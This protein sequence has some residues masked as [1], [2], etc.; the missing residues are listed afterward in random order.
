MNKR[1]YI[2]L[3]IFVICAKP[4]FAQEH[5]NSFIQEII[6]AISEETEDEVDFS[7]L[8]EELENLYDN[9]LDINNATAE[10]LEK[11]IMLN[12][13]QIQSLT[14]Y[15]HKHGKLL[16]KYELKNIDGFNMKTVN[17]VLPF[18]YI[19]STKEVRQWTIKNAFKY[20]R[21]DLFVRFTTLAQEPVGYKSV[22]DSVMNAE[23][24]KHYIGNRHRVYSRYKFN[25]KNKLQFGITAEKDP[26]EQFF[27][28]NQKYGFDYYSGHLMVKDVGIL[29]TAV[30]GDY[31]VLLGQGLTMWS[32]VSGGKSAYVMDIRR[33]GQGLKKYSSV[34]ENSFLRGV[35]ATVSFKN[36]SLTTFGSYKKVDANLSKPTDTLTLDENLFTSFDKMGIHA[37]PR[38]IDNKDAIAEMLAGAN[39]SW[40]MPKFKLGLSGVGLKYDTE[41]QKSDRLY[42]IH[43]F[44]GKQ[45]YNVSADFQFMFRRIH[46]F[47][48]AAMSKNGGWAL[49]SGA[50]LKLSDMAQASVLYRNFATDYQSLYGNAFRESGQVANEQGMF[51]GLEVHPIKK[52]TLTAYYDFFKFPWLKTYSYA[53][54]EGYDYLV[55]A[56]YKTTRSL[57]MY[58]QFKCKDKERNISSEETGLRQLGDEQRMSGRYHLAYSINRQWRIQ[59]R[60]ELSRYNMQ[61]KDTEYGY[62]IYQDL[63]CVPLVNIPLKITMR[64]ALFDTD[65]YS[66]RIYAYESDV[67]YAYSLPSMYNRGTRVYALVKYSVGRKLDF[68]LRYHHTWY[69]NQT[70]IGSGL[71][72]INSNVKS[73]IKLQMRYRF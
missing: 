10:Q 71:N 68:W 45:N 1:I 11:L 72:Q 26:G 41:L 49:V 69:A 7:A 39:I 16:T 8:A 9:P 73:E 47:G 35:G 25:Y 36:I 32:Y 4:L 40:S 29:K 62:M 13:F 70:S 48:E 58:V 42:K 18:I 28:G 22:S 43:Q 52:I 46:F 23:P 50:L 5:D 66:S 20:G 30:V 17:M 34:D 37:T 54:S 53:P 64:Y 44:S 24:N 3:F 31:Q 56:D 63:S 61:N 21:N 59:S 65:G 19:N 2:I 67:L 51:M 12:D 38:Q 27:K 6:E 60:V 57:S 14:D 55:K 33:K 15:I